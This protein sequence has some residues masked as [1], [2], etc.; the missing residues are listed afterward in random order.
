MTANFAMANPDFENIREAYAFEP[1]YK[2]YDR[3]YPENKNLDIIKNGIE[4]RLF[5]PQLHCREHLNVDRW[6]ADLG[7]KK[8]DTVTAFNNRMIGI[9]A[10]FEKGNPFGYMDAFN[11]AYASAEELNKVIKDACDIFENTFGFSSKTFVA[12]CF[13]W[14]DDLENILKAN[15]INGIQCGYWQLLPKG[16][17]DYRRKLNYTG[18]KN[19][20][21][22]IYTVRNCQYEPAYLQNAQECA[23]RCFE[24]VRRAFK[25]RKP[26]VINSHRLNYIG[27]INPENARS[28]L[29]GLKW[30]LERIVSNYADVE[31]ITSNELLEIIS[32]NKKL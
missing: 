6:M 16:K 19:S 25:N 7:S 4:S 3:Y 17:N 26:A 30:L 28:G 14:S 18:E 5:F 2:T 24:E 11:S 29:M 27:S 15:G 20:Q 21:G 8:A 32:E 9:G 23:E 22:Q 31:F 13:V 10:S 1:F 12:S